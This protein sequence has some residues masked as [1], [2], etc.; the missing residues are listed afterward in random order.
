MTSHVR[1]IDLHLQKESKDANAYRIIGS[2]NQ[3]IFERLIDLR[4]SGQCSK[5]SPFLDFFVNKNLELRSLTLTRIHQQALDR[6]LQCTPKLRSL[7]AEDSGLEIAAISKSILDSKLTNLEVLT[8]PDSRMDE[9]NDA[10]IEQCFASLCR[11]QVLNLSGSSGKNGGR[12][13]RSILNGLGA[14]EK[15]IYGKLDLNVTCCNLKEKFRP[16]NHLTSLTITIK[17]SHDKNGSLKAFLSNFPNLESL[18]VGGELKS[19]GKTLDGLLDVLA[20]KESRISY[21]TLRRICDESDLCEFLEKLIER[22]KKLK[23]LDI[24]SYILS[25]DQMKCMLEL[26]KAAN[27]NEPFSLFFKYYTLRKHT[28]YTGQIDGLV[29]R[30]WPSLKV[31]FPY[32][33]YIAENGQV[34]VHMDFT[35][36]QIEDSEKIYRSEVSNSRR[37]LELEKFEESVLNPS[38]EF[39]KSNLELTSSAIKTYRKM[40]K[41]NLEQLA[42]LYPKVHQAKLGQNECRKVS[43]LQTNL[44]ETALDPEQCS[45][46]LSKVLNDL[47]SAIEESIQSFTPL[48]NYEF[49]LNA[50]TREIIAE[51]LNQQVENSFRTM[52]MDLRIKVA[53]QMLSLV[54]KSLKEEFENCLKDF[55]S[56]EELEPMQPSQVNDTYP[57][58][59]VTDIHLFYLST[60]QS[61]ITLSSFYHDS[62]HYLPSP[63]IVQTPVPDLIRQSED[64][65]KSEVPVDV[66]LGRPAPPSQRRPQRNQTEGKRTCIPV[67]TVDLYDTPAVLPQ[68]QT[69]DEAPK[70]Q[71]IG[72]NDAPGSKVMFQ[73][74]PNSITAELLQSR[75]L[76]KVDS[77][78][79]CKLS[80]FQT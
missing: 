47:K 66:R 40:P 16:V 14:V 73:L 48:L 10:V 27:P 4:L 24:R 44:L 25:F 30:K 33:L 32:Q 35:K 42:C 72:L 56:K 52:I 38:E 45:Q 51:S 22:G 75:E 64:K 61:R 50:E 62:N 6:I 34:I 77:P 18:T 69:T 43:S 55:P 5:D 37:L 2:L 3:R 65:P 54:M 15:H 23:H 1:K 71:P 21:L 13:L 36:V 28:S 8:L 68:V 60:A 17:E 74:M 31:C 59:R 19:T 79:L 20:S 39:I 78:S 57:T 7:T 76:K 12:V 46:S 41:R 80:F 9:A 58:E 67:D 26:I 49:T 70:S 29:K 63:T 53:E 11:L